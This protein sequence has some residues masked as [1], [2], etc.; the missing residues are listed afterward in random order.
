MN[1]KCKEGF[2]EIKF[3]ALLDMFIHEVE[4]KQVKEM[5]ESLG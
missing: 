4:N 2:R 3:I 1:H 5:G